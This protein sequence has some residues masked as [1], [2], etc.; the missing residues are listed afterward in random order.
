MRAASVTRSINGH[1]V[2][3]LSKAK[4]MI[5]VCV[6]RINTNALLLPCTWSGNDRDFD[7]TED[8]DPIGFRGDN[9]NTI[10]DG[11]DFATA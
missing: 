11:D 9:Q 3:I 2:F 10:S 6:S 7:L 1:K 4:S 8:L 5:S